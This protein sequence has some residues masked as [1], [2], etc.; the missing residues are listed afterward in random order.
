MFPHCYYSGQKYIFKG[1]PR[2]GESWRTWRGRCPGRL[3]GKGVASRIQVRQA[4]WRTWRLAHLVGSWRG[5]SLTTAHLVTD[6][7]SL[8]LLPCAGKDAH[9]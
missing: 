7:A 3:A 6:N 8:T 1:I 9:P 5:S 2:E 4:S